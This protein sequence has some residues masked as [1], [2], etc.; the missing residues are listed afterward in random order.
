MIYPDEIPPH[1]AVPLALVL[2]AIWVTL[3]ILDIYRRNTMHTRKLTTGQVAERFGVTERTIRDWADAGKL[4]AVTRT[5]G[6][7]RRFD[8]DT[9][10]RLALAS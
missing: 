2:W 7:A 3:S 10:E 4:G 8:A 5:L 1:I 6:G 9:I